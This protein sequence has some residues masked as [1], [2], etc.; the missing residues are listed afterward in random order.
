[1]SDNTKYLRPVI[2]RQGNK[3]SLLKQIESV[4]PEHTKFVEPF[5]GSGVVWLNKE[6]VDVN[7][8]NDLDKSIKTRFSLIK[9]APSDITQ[10]KH[11]KNEQEAQLF[12]NKTPTNNADKLSHFKITQSGGFG[13]QPLS[14]N[15][16]IYSSGTYNIPQN[17]SMQQ[18]I[19]TTKELLKHTKI[20]NQ[21]YVSVI[22]KYDSPNTFFFI[23]PPYK[24]SSDKAF[25]Y[26]E[27]DGTFDYE[28][29]Y[30]TLDNIK[31]MFLLTINDLPEF[32][33]QYK[34]YK[35]KYV[36]VPNPR[37]QSS[38]KELFIMNYEF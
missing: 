21:D 38:R 30:N 17:N 6:P 16:K 10:Y 8:L 1:M 24:G 4:T 15:K 34:N 31:G 33:T 29:L 12:Y 19:I 37:D 18:S 23:D 26:A 5:A 25:G 36:N 32:R 35:I 20:L 27:A 2:G 28:R 14:T 22:K 11:F 3:F 7:I 9:K 13:A